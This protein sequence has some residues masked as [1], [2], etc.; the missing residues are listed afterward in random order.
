MSHEKSHDKSGREVPGNS[1]AS[2]GNS[3]QS[4]V[5]STQMRDGEKMA[6]GPG[7]GVQGNPAKSEDRGGN[8]SGGQGK[9]SQ[10]SSVDT[11]DGAPSRQTSTASEEKGQL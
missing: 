11:N 2:A 10:E 3:G 8:R 9:V 6:G 4:G 1:T 5:D 7:G